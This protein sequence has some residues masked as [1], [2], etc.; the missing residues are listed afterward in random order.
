MS[1]RK[2]STRV[3]AMLLAFAMVVTLIPQVSFAAEAKTYK[4]GPNQKELAAGKYDLPLSMKKATDIN[5]DSMAASAIRGAVMTVKEDGS[6]SITVKMG[7]VSQGGATGWAD[8]WQIYSEYGFPN[9]SELIPCEYT[10]KNLGKITVQDSITFNLPYTDK[11]GVYVHMNIDIM[12]S[13]QDAFFKIDF[14]N[15]VVHVDKPEYVVNFTSGVNGKITAEVNGHI[16]QSGES[17]AKDE[18]VTFEAIPNEGYG[19]EKWTGVEAEGNTIT[20]LVDKDLN[21][22]VEFVELSKLSYAVS[23][24][25]TG[26]GSIKAFVNDKEIKSGDKVKHGEKVVFKAM[27]EAGHKTEWSGISGNGNEASIILKSKIAV[28]A[29]FKLIMD[30]TELDKS[31]NNAEAIIKDANNYA[32]DEAWKELEERL[33]IAKNPDEY[34][35]QTQLD[36]VKKDLDKAITKVTKLNKKELSDAVNKAKGSEYSDYTIAL[37]K[38]VSNAIEK[39][40]QY[41]GYNPARAASQKVLDDITNELNAA[42]KAIEDYKATAEPVVQV[43]HSE[44]E[45]TKYISFAKAMAAAKEDETVTLL[46]DVDTQYANGKCKALDLGKHALTVGAGSCNI[47]PVS[48]GTL[49]ANLGASGDVTLGKDI[50][51]NGQISTNGKLTI[52]GATINAPKGKSIIKENGSGN[53]FISEIIVNSGKISSDSYYAIE[54]TFDSNANK[55]SKITINEGSVVTGKDYAIC[56]LGEVIING[57]KFGGNVAVVRGSNPTVPSNKKLSTVKQ[58]SGYFEL[59]DASVEE[60]KGED[61]IEINGIKY[62][63]IESAIKAVKSGETIKLLKDVKLTKFVEITKNCTIDLNGFTFD[64]FAFNVSG[65]NYE[66]WRGE[67]GDSNWC[68]LRIGKD[69]IVNVVDNSKNATGKLT[70][71]S[72]GEYDT[73]I[74]VYGEFNAKDIIVENMNSKGQDLSALVIPYNDNKAKVTLD[75][76]KLSKDNKGIILGNASVGG[77][78][79]LRNI[80]ATFDSQADSIIGGARNN[81]EST[82]Y[83]IENCN[84]TDKVTTDRDGSRNIAGSIDMKNTTWNFTNDGQLIADDHEKKTNIAMTGCTITSENGERALWIKSTDK[85]TIND[86]TVKAANGYAMELVNDRMRDYVIESGTFEGKN[87]SLKATVVYINGGKFKGAIEGTT[88]LPEGKTLKLENGYYVLANGIA[89]SG[90]DATVYNASG[91][92]IGKIGFAAGTAPAAGVPN[93]GRVVLDK[94]ITL[95]GSINLSMIKGGRYTIDLNG[96]NFTILESENWGNPNLVSIKNNTAVT[97][98]DSL[99]TA[100]VNAETD[101]WEIGVEEKTSM[102]I[103]GGTWNMQVGLMGASGILKVTG[104]HI[105]TAGMMGYGAPGIIVTGGDFN[106]DVSQPIPDWDGNIASD[107]VPHD[108]H[109]AIEKDGRWYV[110]PYTEMPVPENPV[111]TPESKNFLANEKIEV[112]ISEVAGAKVYYT[113][114]G[115]RPTADGT[116]YENSFMIDT[117]T[118]VKAIAIA[119]K[120]KQVSE[121]AEANYKLVS[122]DLSLLEK[123]KAESKKDIYTSSSLKALKAAITDAEKAFANKDADAIEKANVK[124]GNAIKWL[125]KKPEIDTELDYR[126]LKDGVYQV[127]GKMIKSVSDDVSM[128]DKGIDH[129]IKLT[130]KDGKYYITLNFKGITIGDKFGYLK[131]LKYFKSGYIRNQYGEPVGDKE[132]VKVES[133]QLDKNG[134]L[135]ADNFGTDY[136]DIMT[137]ELIPEA[138]DDGKVPLEVFVPIMEAIS[139]G[140]GTQTVFLTLDWKTIALYD[141]SVKPEPDTPEVPEVKPAEHAILNGANQIVNVAGEDV[142]IRLQGEPSELVAVFM[143]GKLVK[144]TNYEITKGSVVVTFDKEYIASLGAGKHTVGFK[145]NNGEIVETSLTLSADAAKPGAPKTGDTANMLPWMV[146]A[147]AAGSAVVAVRRKED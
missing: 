93:N 145:F 89:E 69:A 95:D 36:R 70:Q 106:T 55:Y 140:N 141:E 92:L 76:V 133:Y 45:P 13:E 42:V 17:V 48:N 121:I 22:G 117:T 96:H 33:A 126:N 112:S 21:V 62:K 58:A 14:D 116:L 138:L 142:S 2:M 1:E 143:D 103:A 56:S 66:Q 86:C 65:T 3:L 104:G 31:I 75:G 136:P 68:I 139:A 101:P 91:K 98:K 64:I 24:K 53:N 113:L 128:A 19:I 135:I 77:T 39:A 94:D 27:P 82:K 144:R 25:S 32:D 35:N 18:F 100:I 67:K 97:F 4:F 83:V 146:L 107:P 10:E 137:F 47:Y 134:N 147:L 49:N 26:N 81:A 110:M 8:S 119:D 44:G 79:I 122:P 114:D 99:D 88:L 50:T 43:L 29:N 102:T 115:S 6:A 23:F 109:G 40:N 127:N 37:F 105:N 132:K 60:A 125:E 16:I 34:S 72:S 51:I 61:I 52:N 80:T 130:V 78:S 74:V 120:S 118:T 59:I 57:G 87:V 131:E 108:T 38:G 46:K 12:G 20:T 85:L 30:R 7:A 63:T 9:K 54:P 41:V 84:F 124:L 111:I 15:A 123:A 73:A 90:N 11:D 28:I 5:Q 71:Q 129:R